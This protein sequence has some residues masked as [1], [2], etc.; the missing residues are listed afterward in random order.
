MGRHEPEPVAVVSV[1]TR[2]RTD[3]EHAMAAARTR[4]AFRL[5][6]VLWIHDA[7]AT[8][9]ASMTPEERLVAAELAGVRPASD[10]TWACVVA[11]LGIWE[12][13]L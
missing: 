2:V 6:S 7:T 3:G 4:K 5:A 13:G 1:D 8:V 12:A 10:T 9:A 11:L